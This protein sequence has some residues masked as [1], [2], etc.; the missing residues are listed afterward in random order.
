[1]PLRAFV[2]GLPLAAIITNIMLVDDLSDITIDTA[3]GWRTRAVVWGARWTR[4]EYVA[5]MA[6]ACA[7]PFWFWRGLGF[8]AWVLLPLVTA[9]LA[10]RAIRRV[11]TIEP[12]DVELM[13]PKT[14]ASD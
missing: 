1:M 4:C 6:L 12:A 5:F 9:P 3:K 13:S 14:A 7:F 10:L 8:D 2:I 11:Y